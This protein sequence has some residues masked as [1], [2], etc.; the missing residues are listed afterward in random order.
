MVKCSTLPS[1]QGQISVFALRLPPNLQFFL[2]LIFTMVV[3]F[4]EV[5][6]NL[7][8]HKFIQS[9]D[10]LGMVI[11]IYIKARRKS[12]MQQLQKGIGLLILKGTLIF[13][14]KSFI[15]SISRFSLEMNQ[16][17]KDAIHPKF[18]AFSYQLFPTPKESLRSGGTWGA[19]LQ[20]TQAQGRAVPHRAP[21]PAWLALC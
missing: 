20:A 10:S 4:C 9:S 3:D 19:F 8:L 6:C 7:N 15:I 14:Q 16:F 12:Y 17:R 11:G 1:G 5:L 2:N 21:A 13:F 18:C